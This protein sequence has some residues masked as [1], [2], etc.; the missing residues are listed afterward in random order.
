MTSSRRERVRTL[1]GGAGEDL[2]G[3][4][5]EATSTTLTRP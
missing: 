5:G 1:A 4:V 3:Y 2:L